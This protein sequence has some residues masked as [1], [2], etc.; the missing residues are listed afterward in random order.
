MVCHF[1]YLAKNHR[2]CGFVMR[3][4]ELITDRKRFTELFE[5]NKIHEHVFLLLSFQFWLCV[6]AKYW[7][8]PT[9][10]NFRSTRPSQLRRTVKVNRD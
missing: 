2:E 8:K 10:L 3:T 5:N 4:Q 9:L 6:G 7:A 1:S